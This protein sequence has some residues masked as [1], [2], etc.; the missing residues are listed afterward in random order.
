VDAGPI[1][2]G[3]SPAANA[4]GLA[5]AKVNGR[6]DHAYTLGRQVLAACWPLPWGGML[7]TRLLSDPVHAPYVGE[8]CMLFFLSN[9][10]P[11][12]ATLSSVRGPLPVVGA[13][14]GVYFGVGGL[15]LAAVW[16]RGRRTR[17]CVV[18]QA[19]VQLLVWAGLIV[20][21]GVMV[22]TGR[23]SIGLIAL[24]L[25]Q[26]LPRVRRAAETDRAH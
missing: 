5:A 7:G 2:A 20:T 14:Y 8:A 24:L 25:A 10:A 3:F 21:G 12:D 9:P 13:L 6:L 4:F 15:I 18:P 26:I 1:L 11:P 22:L 17:G 16:L 19:W 23:P